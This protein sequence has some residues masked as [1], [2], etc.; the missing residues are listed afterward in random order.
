MNIPVITNE[1][2]SVL[3]EQLDKAIPDVPV[4]S[5]KLNEYGETFSFQC[6]CG[7]HHKFGYLKGNDGYYLS[8]D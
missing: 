4:S 6:S 7:A 8:V 5:K 2:F 1:D 3:K